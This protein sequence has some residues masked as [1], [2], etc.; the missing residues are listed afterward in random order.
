M[1]DNVYHFNR[2]VFKGS[3]DI[4]IDAPQG[5]NPNPNRFFIHSLLEMH[6]SSTLLLNFVYVLEQTANWKFIISPKARVNLGHLRIDRAWTV[7]VGAGASFDVQG[8]LSIQRHALLSLSSG[9]NS[10]FG[11]VFTLHRKGN[12]SLSDRLVTMNSKWTLDG[13]VN[14]SNSTTVVKGKLNWNRGFV[15]GRQSATVRLLRGCEIAG[16]LPKTLDGIAVE[17]AADKHSVQHGIIA[18]YFQSKKWQLGMHE[19]KPLYD[20]HFPGTDSVGPYTKTLP[21]EF[22]LPSTKGEMIRFK[23]S[24]D[25]EPE[26]I[27]PVRS[28]GWSPSVLAL[29]P[30]EVTEPFILSYAARLSTYLQIDRS[31]FY[32]FFFSM[33]RGLKIR[34][35]L[36]GTFYYK[37]NVSLSFLD[38]VETSAIHIKAGL[39]LMRVDYISQDKELRKTHSATY[40]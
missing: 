19:T 7:S 23:P 3:W 15:K 37:S 40:R 14:L 12:L 35:S 26:M 9:P 24:F 20:L 16:S 5:G 25:S 29:S 17:I 27:K 33:G 30:S 1:F 4:F 36:D 21:P 8:E 34:L 13:H 38:E 32:T 10:V 11:D 6:R 2:I 31:G 18:E 28:P 39:R 22:D